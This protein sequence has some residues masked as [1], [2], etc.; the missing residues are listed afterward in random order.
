M[1][2]IAR[3]RLGRAFLAP[4]VALALIVGYVIYTQTGSG[5]ASRPSGAP[6][7]PAP[8]PKKLTAADLILAASTAKG[9]HLEY[10]GITGAPSA[11]HNNHIEI[12]S[13]QWGMGVAAPP[14]TGGTPGRPSLSD[15][16]LTKQTDKYTVPLLKNSLKTTKVLRA[17]V[18]FT[19]V[20]A[21]GIAFDYL[22]MTLRNVL[23]TGY[24][25]SSGGDIPSESLSLNYTAL[26]ITGRVTGSPVQT[27]TYDA[28][29]NTTT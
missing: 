8:A 19:D 7:A 29:T 3:R 18:Y 11:M 25:L 14:P 26:T 13:F 20:N 16:T 4:L 12:S 2:L 22:E 27:V 23:I 21:S 10:D 5:T 1:E 9:I 24:S 17:V 15:V 28:A 6:A